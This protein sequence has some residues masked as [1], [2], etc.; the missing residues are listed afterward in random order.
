MRRLYYSSGSFYTGDVV[1][2]AVLRYARVLADTGK[3]DI[4][5][6]PVVTDAGISGHAHVLV[7][8]ASQLFSIPV[9][10]EDEDPYDADIVD[11]LLQKTRAL[12]PSR[13][14]TPRTPQDALDLGDFDEA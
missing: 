9:A 2:K 13:P 11:D 14:T 10:S 6:I 1:S 3:A 5:A 4:I 8:P 12:L 7:G